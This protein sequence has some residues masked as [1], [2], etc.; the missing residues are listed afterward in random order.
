MQA[1]VV[2]AVAR[3]ES[4]QKS[5][6][7]RRKHLELAERGRPTGGGYRPFGFEEDRMTI[8][9]AEAVKI[10]EAAARV[11][12][13]DSVCGICAEW[14]GH[15]P[16]PVR[17]V[18]WYPEVLK[19]I[20]VAPRTAGLRSYHGEVI[21]EAVWEPILD[22]VTWERVRRLLLDPAR[23]HRGPRRRYLLSGLVM[24][25]RCDNLMTGHASRGNPC[26]RCK[27]GCSMQILAEPLEA[28]VVGAVSAVLATPALWRA[29]A[30]RDAGED[31]RL[32]REMDGLRARLEDLADMFA[33][34][35]VT[36]V[37]WVRARR[38]LV[39]RLDELGCL[40]DAGVRAEALRAVD[41]DMLE[42]LPAERLR[43]V[44]AAV[45]DCVVISSGVPGSTRF[46]SGRVSIN[47]LA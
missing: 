12:A 44:V 31:V 13:G 16:A 23:T 36:R 4:E 21:G 33:S 19:H 45:V 8:R 17:G 5:E 2:G 1:R 20:L 43:A 41:G 40:L 11:L 22:R 32:V 30:E 9:E 14:S 35:E 27:T 29:V 42:G 7:T 3:H 18:R 37:E 38:S 26:Y 6:R 47:W 34:G 15:G 10:R 39:A 24:C 28:L 46:D 25:G